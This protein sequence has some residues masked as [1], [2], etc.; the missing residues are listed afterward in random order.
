MNAS[1]QAR[2]PHPLR[3]GQRRQRE[4]PGAKVLLGLYQGVVA[5]H[6]WTDVQSEEEVGIAALCD[7]GSLALYVD[8]ARPTYADVLGI[9]I[10][11]A[12]SYEARRAA[13]IDAIGW[14]MAEEPPWLDTDEQ[15]EVMP[16]ADTAES[17]TRWL[18][19]ELGSDD[20]S[21]NLLERWA[22]HSSTIYAP[23]FSLAH[24]L[25]PEEAKGLG[26]RCADLGGPASSVPCV[27]TTATMEKLNEVISAKGL[28]FLVVEELDYLPL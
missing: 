25:T 27:A 14:D 24:S 7:D 21:M 13:V 2:T 11:D 23:G 9:A 18:N 6:D 15:G 5:A 4:S 16:A 1:R 28:P 3:R 26:I 19:S 20:Y 8:K 22:S 10:E 12:A 17:L